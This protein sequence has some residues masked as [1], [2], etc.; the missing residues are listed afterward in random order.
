MKEEK[1][2]KLSEII[3]YNQDNFYTIAVFETTSEQFV[4][5]GYLPDP[6]LGR[7]YLLVGEWVNHP[8]YGEQFAFSSFTES[9]PTSE[10]GILN[11]LA[12]G[13][14]RGVGIATALLIVKKFGKDSLKIISENPERLTEIKGI[15]DAKASQIAESY[16]AQR[17]YAEVMMQLS[18]FD[19]ASS[20]CMK[21]Y[22]VYGSKS[23]E[24]IK[25]NPYRLIDD[26]Y[27]I[28]F[29]KADAIAEK[30]GFAKDS[31]FRI[32]SALLYVLKRAALN[33]NTYLSKTELIEATAAL[34]DQP[35]ELVSD[36]LYNMVLENRL[37]AEKLDGQD[38]VMLHYYFKAE[39]HVAALLYRL[40]HES[41]NA[42]AIN[43]EKQI[44]ITEK[45]TGMQLSDTQKLAVVSSLCSG[46]SIITGGPGTGKTTVINTILSIL[47]ASNVKTALAAPTGRAAKRMEETT[48]QAASTI[49]R[50]LEYQYADDGESMHFG[51]NEENQLDFDCIIVDEMSMVDILLMDGLLSAIKPGTRLILVGDADQLP[52]VGA[53]NVLKDMLASE[54]IHVVRLTD[55][56]RQA[57]ESLI[58]VNAHLINKGEYPSFNEK[59][60]DFFMFARQS[61][62]EILD[63]IKELCAVRLPKY[64]NCEDALSK[65]QVLTP[66]RKGM[67]GSIELN[68]S[69]QEVLNPAAE[70][71]AEKSFAGRIYRLGDKVMQNKNDYDLEW[72][73]LKDFET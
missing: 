43:F 13:A 52:P 22:K 44:A 33:G 14:I 58:V 24:I 6:K 19:I 51:K 34:L 27:S 31:E 2:T 68:K 49:H 3:Y 66:M 61:E 42:L 29:Q 4:A 17:E 73:D 30:M 70:G 23:V 28:G 1:S 9:M 11:F 45:K 40:S 26:V 57:A 67:L 25:E 59:D 47:N 56:F 8:K 16:A 64:L 71:K 38:V 35:R 37:C 20:A 54:K 72:K 62:Q 50:L 5:T 36:T 60:K 53:G 15:G 69:L 21:L 39:R 41:I 32:K 63:T 7:E 65:I 12:S 48:G 46:V 55:I 10:E 18:A